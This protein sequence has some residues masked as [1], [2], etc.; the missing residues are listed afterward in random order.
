[1]GNLSQSFS[2][3]LIL[4][5]AVSS[6]TV[7]F[8]TIS[9][10]L[11][12]SGSN[13]IS[14]VQGNA[15]E[16]TFSNTIPIN[17]TATPQDG[18]VLIAA[19]GAG[20]NDSTIG[21][22]KITEGGVRWT[23]IDSYDIPSSEVMRPHYPLESY[24]C[25][26]WIGIVDSGANSSLT[27]DLTNIATYGATCD[28]CEYNN[29]NTTAPLDQYG[30]SAIEDYGTSLPTGFTP[31]TTQSNELWI[32]AIW[33]DGGQQSTA[34]G[35]FVLMDGTA[36]SYGNS[37]SFV[38]KIVD[39][40]GV[41]S[42]NTTISPLTYP[43]NYVGIIATFRGVPGSTPTPTSTPTPSPTPTEAK[44]LSYI[45]Y[46]APSNTVLAEYAGDLVAVGE[47][48]NVGS[49]VIGTAV[50]SGTAA[51]A[52]GT[53]VASN[54]AEA[55]TDANYGLLPGQ[56]APFYID[57]PP[58][59]SITQ[60]QSWV[61]IV[62]NVT[63]KVTYVSD[64]S[65]T[66]FS[67]LTE[68]DLAASVN[69][70]TYTVTGTIQ[71]TGTQTTGNVWLETT[72]YNAS[73]IVIGLNFTD[74]LTNSLA[75]GASVPFTATPTDNTAKLSSEITS[76]SLLIQAESPTSSASPTPSPTATPTPT[77]IPTP[78]VSPNPTPTPTQA[79]I[80]PIPNLSF[81][82]I[83]SSPSSGF[84]VQIQGSLTYNGVG[85]SDA[86][87]QLSD[88]VTG[89]RSWQDL[90]YLITGSDGNF[91]CMWNPSVSGNYGIEAT[92]SGD[93]DYSNAS[94]V[95][96]FAIV[97]FNSQNQNVFSVTSNSTLTSLTFNSATNELS[98]GVSGP[99]GTTGL[100]TVCIP[101]SLVPNIS[102]L[103]V[104]LNGTSI[105]YTSAFVDNVWLIT[106]TYHHSSHTVVIA[107]GASTVPEFP[108]L[109]ILPLFAIAILLST[110]FI[111]KRIP[112]K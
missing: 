22:N 64:I 43:S 70:G 89:G 56:K 39:E 12:Q 72:F 49:N 106:F 44:I 25:E 95:Y 112:K 46:V 65:N 40:T 66:Q 98:F 17:L 79:P 76:Y 14:R 68:A 45:W 37:L 91:T 15:N 100:T 33:T 20:C 102:K 57:F 27:V 30:N 58:E 36:N 88:S 9:F 80:L 54:E 62:T 109:I 63:I 48:Q 53:V 38:E 1:M 55:Y 41:A 84:N 103:N 86:G 69:R 23:P 32:G 110:V 42:S 21:V 81:Y 19:V 71:N 93:S 47:I 26:I 73:G 3:L 29:I 10:G 34:G 92:W 107:L 97:P 4:I 87:I 96:N 6:L 7:I 8:A 99:S 78:T 77:P 2:L 67:G 11:A 16:S 83:S 50:V 85:L 90:T 111:R 101:Q 75:P 74:Y 59:D 82:C 28:V 31:P 105:N 51:L 104:M 35:G 18:D 24:T 13:E 108:T 60:N 94:A 5:L 61:P 52:N